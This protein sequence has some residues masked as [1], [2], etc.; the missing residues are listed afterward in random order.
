MN[1]AALL[2]DLDRLDSDLAQREAAIS[3]VRRRQAQNPEVAAAERRAEALRDALA[4]AEREQRAAEAELSD[5]EGRLARDNGRLYSGAIV[6]PRE[7]ASL[8]REIAGYRERLAQAE[9]RCLEVMERVERLS[10]ESTEAARAANAQRERWEADREPLGRRIE[11]MVDAL[12]GLRAERESLAGRLD[13][14][15]LE[16]YGR[17]RASLGHAVAPVQAGICTA[18]H[19]TIP[20]KDIQHARESLIPCPN[21][22]RILLP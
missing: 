1:S 11:G 14:R 21:C 15:T 18:C 10:R 12:A 8:E 19:V 7:L 17:L 16:R 20:P 6:D 3:E 13:A 9:E 2:R 5:L 4:G 22:G